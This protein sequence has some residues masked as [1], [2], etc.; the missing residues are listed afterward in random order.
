MKRQTNL[1]SPEIKREM[2]TIEFRKEEFD[3]CFHFYQDDK[4]QYQYT[5]T[6][7]DELNYTQLLNKYRSKH[8]LPFPEEIKAIREKYQLP[9]SKMSDILGFGANSYRQ[10]EA[11]EVPSQSNGK[12]IQMAEDPKKFKD[13]ILLCESIDED[14]RYK[15]LNRVNR[16]MEKE[17]DGLQWINVD[18]YFADHIRPSEL[19]G[20]RKPNMERF[21]HLIIRFAEKL[22]PWKT[23]LNKLLF[24]A[25][26]LHYKRHAVSITGCRYTA[27]QMGPVPKRFETVFD[28]LATKDFFDVVYTQFP[29]GNSGEQFKKRGDHPFNSELFTEQELET[30]EYVIGTLGKLKRPALVET[31]HKEK[32]WIENQ[33]TK[34]LINYEFAFE[35]KAL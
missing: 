8:H 18:D 22:E 28:E 17:G 6:E 14:A 30:I 29:G 35:L 26:F 15:I 33:K 7:L 10:Y 4:R 23:Q 12:L 24:Y 5:T 1:I 21:A 16:F 27:I 20:Y 19:T 34:G 25:D 11:G 32:G 3:I 2:R 9:A 13:L 31:S